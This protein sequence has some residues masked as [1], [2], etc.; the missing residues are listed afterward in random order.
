[1]S[2]IDDIAGDFKKSV[3]NKIDERKNGRKNK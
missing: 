3:V 2:E 1:M